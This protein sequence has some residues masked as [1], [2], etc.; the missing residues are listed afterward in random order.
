VT[1]TGPARVGGG[2][3]PSN[4]PGAS[5]AGRRDSPWGRP[6][7]VRSRRGCPDCTLDTHTVWTPDRAA[8]T[9]P[10]RHRRRCCRLAGSWGAEGSQGARHHRVLVI[11]GC[12]SAD[13]GPCDQQGHNHEGSDHHDVIRWGALSYPVW[14]EAHGASIA[15]GC[16]ER[17]PTGRWRWKPAVA[18][19]WGRAPSRC[20][21][22]PSLACDGAPG[23]SHSGGRQ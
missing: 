4:T 19:S 18:R 20:G 11:T 2:A 10:R 17:T 6:P 12:S 9:A 15:G 23:L 21:C 8:Q 3:W 22:R 7:C 14:I 16:H 5:G 1:V 13:Q